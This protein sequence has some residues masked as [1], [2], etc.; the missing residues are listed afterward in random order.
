MIGPFHSIFTDISDYLLTKFTNKN[1][2]WSLLFK[3]YKL[4]YFSYRYSVLLTNYYVNWRG[5]LTKGETRK[6]NDISYPHVQWCQPPKSASWGAEDIVNTLWGTCTIGAM[7]FLAPGHYQWI[8]CRE[9]KSPRQNH[10]H[11]N[12]LYLAGTLTK[13][14][15]QECSCYACCISPSPEHFCFVDW[16]WVSMPTDASRPTTSSI[17]LQTMQMLCWQGTNS[18]QTQ[19]AYTETPTLTSAEYPKSSQSM[20]QHG[21]YCCGHQ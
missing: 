20:A 18:S 16:Q 11:Y 7:S 13:C 10:D 21:V 19:P 14:G 1:L 2:F 4:V 5:A 17:N 6:G 15:L 3:L 12:R 8:G 9:M